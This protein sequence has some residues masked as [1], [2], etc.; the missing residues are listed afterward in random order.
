M[1]KFVWVVTGRAD[2]G[3]IERKEQ[4]QREQYTRFHPDAAQKPR[5]KADL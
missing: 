4:A 2:E 3:W 5:L 1:I